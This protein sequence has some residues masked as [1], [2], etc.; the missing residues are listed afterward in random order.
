MKSPSAHLVVEALVLST[1]QSCLKNGY[2]RMKVVA[3]PVGNT[4]PV[5]G[6]CNLYQC[7][8]VVIGGHDN[9][10]FVNEDYVTTVQTVTRSQSLS[11]SFITNSPGSQLTSTH[12]PVQGPLN[13]QQMNT[14]LLNFFLP[15][16]NSVSHGQTMLADKTRTTTVS[17]SENRTVSPSQT[18]PP[19][20]VNYD[21]KHRLYA[22][23][24]GV[25]AAGLLCVIFI[26]L[27]IT[28][29]IFL[30]R[31]GESCTEHHNY[32]FCTLLSTIS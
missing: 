20:A 10:V 22:M 19:T 4:C 2:S 16:T 12:F 30:C 14:H 29:L 15:S 28:C 7:A 21:K 25:L 13:T 8:N 11:V 32:L 6:T 23:L 27:T 5:E 24:G 3:N 26:V 1:W 17:N 31:R 18:P 9:H